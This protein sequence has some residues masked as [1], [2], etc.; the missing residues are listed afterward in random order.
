MLAD[1]LVVAGL[2]IAPVHGTHERDASTGGSVR[3]FR[4]R[5]MVAPEKGENPGGLILS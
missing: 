1:F 2:K 4:I 3:N 5:G